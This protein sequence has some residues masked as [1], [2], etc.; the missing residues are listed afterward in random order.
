MPAAIGVTSRASLSE[1]GARD[2]GA[3]HLLQRQHVG[4]DRVDGEADPVHPVEHGGK[5]I[6]PARIEG[7]AHEAGAVGAVGDGV[8]AAAAERAESREPAGVARARRIARR[9]MH[10]A[11]AL[12]RHRIFVAAGQI[13]GAI[14]NGCDIGRQRHEAVIA[15]DHDQR[16]RVRDR[17]DDIAE[18]SAGR[19][20]IEEHLADEDEIVAAAARRGREALGKARERLGGDPLDGD[21]PV[22]LEAGDL[23]GEGVEFAVAGEHARQPICRQ[24]GEEAPDEIVRVGRERD[25][26]GIGQGEDR[27]D[28]ALR[29]RDHFAEDDLPLVVGQPRGVGECPAMSL[30]RRVRPEMMAVRRKM[31][32]AGPRRRETR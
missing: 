18:R 20:R 10:E 15:V 9:A 2:L 3:E 12:A 32:A 8:A 5:A 27:G 21:Q 16:L 19:R 24:R 6:E 14:G 28:A 31:D 4:V 30:A 23:T 1:F 22:L 13:E 17:A 7:R 29:A 11:G 26:R 25:R